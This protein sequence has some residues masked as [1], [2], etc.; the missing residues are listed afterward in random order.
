MKPHFIARKGGAKVGFKRTPRLGCAIHSA[1][2]PDIT[3][4]P[5]GLC[6]IKREIGILQKGFGSIAVIGRIGD[7]DAGA[8]DNLIPINQERQRK[9][10]NNPR[11]QLFN[12]C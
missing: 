9:R 11:R 10:L 8:G 7:P 2:E 12:R 5:F 6:R 3:T 4:A 1:F